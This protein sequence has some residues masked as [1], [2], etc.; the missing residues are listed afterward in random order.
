[1]LRSQSWGHLV[2]R[3]LETPSRLKGSYRS[4]RLK[5]PVR[6]GGEEGRLSPEEGKSRACLLA[7]GGR[8]ANPWEGESGKSC[9]RE[10]DVKKL[11]AGQECGT[12]VLR[13]L[14]PPTAVAWRR[15]V[16]R[17][18]TA[19][20]RACG[21]LPAEWSPEWG[22]VRFELQD[23]ARGQGALGGAALPGLALGAGLPAASPGSPW[24]PV[25]AYEARGGEEPSWSAQP[26]IEGGRPGPGPRPGPPAPFAAAAVFVADSVLTEAAARRG[27]GQLP[28]LPRPAPAPAL[29]SSRGR[30]GGPFCR[31]P[32]RP[33]SSLPSLD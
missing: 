6:L 19:E 17:R 7:T 2:E 23:A 21:S 8:G 20:I 25:P 13:S 12:K 26:R 30:G 22:A 18:L 15:S 31:R 5:P 32:W 3:P 27:S 4:A 16:R 14:R 24:Q 9:S 1:M 10:R 29:L 33:F 28:S 11:G